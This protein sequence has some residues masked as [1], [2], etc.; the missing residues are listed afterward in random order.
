[1]RIIQFDLG[2]WSGDGHN[3]TY[4]LFISTN[5]SADEI[6]DAYHKTVEAIGFDLAEQVA[7]EYHSITA[8]SLKR[9]T[10][11]G[12]IPSG[13]LDADWLTPDELFS[14]FLVF[15][16]YSDPCAILDLWKPDEI[17]FGVTNRRFS[18]GYGIIS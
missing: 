15:V 1:M 14:M 11:I 18:L 4:P 10:D 9:L 16:R 8:E 17:F 12:Y 5:R 7:Q 2:D 13:E 3:K 6:A